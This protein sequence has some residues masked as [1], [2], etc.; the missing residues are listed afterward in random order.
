[1]V[2]FL[3][4]IAK[5]FYVRWEVI[6]FCY[7]EYFY[8]V[9]HLCT[10]RTYSKQEKLKASI[11]LQSH[12]VEKGLSLKDVRPQFGVAK[13]K[14]LLE[15]LSFYE[16]HFHDFQLLVFSIS[17]IEAYIQHHEAIGVQVD[18][19]ISTHYARLRGKIPE[20]AWTR[21]HNLK[22]GTDS[23]SQE[24]EIQKNS[25]PFSTF[26]K[27]RHSIRSFTGEQVSRNQI[28]AALQIAEHT[29]SACNRQPWSIYVY[30]KKENIVTLLDIQSGARQFKEDVGAIVVVCS[31]ANAFSI[32]EGHQPYVNGALY[33]MNL[34]YAFHSLGLG[35]IPLN[36][37][38]SHSRLEKLKKTGG[39]SASDIPVMLIA[40]G[41]VCDEYKTAC[42]KRFPFT[43]YTKFD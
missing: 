20:E 17:I 41:H 4:T 12:I 8:L 38:I 32:T 22:G 28:E 35:T 19:Y 37:G 2:V 39:I 43:D 13:I 10:N 42:S 25:F 26:V 5:Y 30:N 23:F 27:T 21:Y 36:L 18:S 31:T 9:R 3:K 16:S 7:L 14:R 40:V 6:K 11:I 15:D 34:I 1:M 29:P 33:A 24:E